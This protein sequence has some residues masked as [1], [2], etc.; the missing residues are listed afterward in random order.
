M[1]Q[2]MFII[3]TSR[4]RCRGCRPG[5][6]T[7][8]GRGGRGKRRERNCCGLS[9][10]VLSV[11]SAIEIIQL[12]TNQ[13]PP[14]VHLQEGLASSCS[15]Q[16]CRSC[17]PVARPPAGRAV[18]PFSLGTNTSAGLRNRSHWR[19]P[20]TCEFMCSTNNTS[21]IKMCPIVTGHRRLIIKP[22]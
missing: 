8:P 14:Q 12:L 16:R 11:Y 10:E 21:T 17:L 7:S 19:G 5:K 13:L 3:Q 18:V 9:A 1:H 4:C 6:R 20:S 15:P 2:L 22:M